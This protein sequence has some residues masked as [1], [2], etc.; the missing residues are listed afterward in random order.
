MSGQMDG[1]DLYIPGLKY[2]IGGGLIGRDGA[3]GPIR[4]VVFYTLNHPP[5]PFYSISL[6]A[7]LRGASLPFY[8]PFLRCS[9][10]G[11]TI[12][13]FIEMTLLPLGIRR[14]LSFRCCC[15]TL[16]RLVETETME[17]SNC[18][19]RIECRNKRCN[20]NKVVLINQV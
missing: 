13:I 2:T 17:P 12:S 9:P 19:T 20:T 18:Y 14:N 7:I 3:T 5:H 10:S 6:N 4:S 15:G 11:R 8:L 1:T 16:L